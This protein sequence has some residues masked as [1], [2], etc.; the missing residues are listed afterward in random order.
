MAAEKPQTVTQ[1]AVAEG[2][3]DGDDPQVQA[4]IEAE[5]ERAEEGTKR[6]KELEKKLEP[7]RG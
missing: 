5:K 2:N 1:F 7:R 4:V 6:A 3:L